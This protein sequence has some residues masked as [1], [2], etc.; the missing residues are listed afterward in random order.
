MVV[1]PVIVEINII[2]AKNLAINIVVVGINVA[3]GVVSII[4]LLARNLSQTSREYNTY[5]TISS[6]LG[7]FGSSS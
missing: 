4:R 5:L 2:A 6:Q 7:S 1:I 3:V